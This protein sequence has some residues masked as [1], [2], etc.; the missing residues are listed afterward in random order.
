MTVDIGGFV[1]GIIHI[2]IYKTPPCFTMCTSITPHYWWTDN[3]LEPP[4]MDAK[5][6]PLQ[7]IPRVCAQRRQYPSSRVRTDRSIDGRCCWTRK[8][9]C[10]NHMADIKQDAIPAD[11]VS[12][13][14]RPDWSWSPSFQLG[15]PCG[16]VPNEIAIGIPSAAPVSDIILCTL[17]QRAIRIEEDNQG[18]MEGGRGFLH[19]N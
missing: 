5:A 16:H 11:D 6:N 18:G 2:Y 14:I 9:G 7:I 10:I 15:S 17:M 4:N 8:R 19:V 13:R 1:C 12:V 3:T